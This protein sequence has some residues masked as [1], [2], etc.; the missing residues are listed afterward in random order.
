MRLMKTMGQA[1]IEIESQQGKYG[2]VNS[3][4]QYINRETLRV[5]HVK[6]PKGKA[7]GVDGIT[8]EMYEENIDEILI[9]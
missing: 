4:M 7:S 5:E 3:L 1:K 6:Q 9:N 8:K 2:K